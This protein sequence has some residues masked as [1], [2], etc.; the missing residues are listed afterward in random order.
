MKRFIFAILFALALPAQA[1]TTYFCNSTGVGADPVSISGS[2]TNTGASTLAGATGPKQ[3]LA[4]FV[5]AFAAA[6]AGDQLLMCNGGAWDNWKMGTTIPRGNAVGTYATNPIIIGNF[7]PTQFTSSALPILTAP[8]NVGTLAITGITKAFPAV[9][10]ANNA[11][12]NGDDVVIGV[13]AGMPEIEGTRGTVSAVTATSFSVNID[14]SLFTTAGT[15]GVGYLACPYNDFNSYCGAFSF[16]PTGGNGGGTTAYGGWTFQNLHIKGGPGYGSSGIGIQQNASFI[17]IKNM[18]IDHLDS[19]FGCNN[20]NQTVSSHDISLINNN[21]SYTWGHG[22]LSWGCNNVLIDG[23]TFDHTANGNR[24]NYHKLRDHAMYVSGNENLPAT[25]APDGFGII[26]RN[27]TITNTGLNQRAAQFPAY[28]GNAADINSCN[29]AVVVGH[30]RIA[31]WVFEN[32]LIM[33]AVGTA[34]QGCYGVG[35]GPANYD[36]PGYFEYQK[37]LVIRGNRII[38]VGNVAYET[39]P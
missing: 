12:L 13:I 22:L 3:T 27:N 20:S 26:I 35:F 5:A 6:V 8:G 2:D 32:N 38:N 39:G 31:N 4:A 10:T 28:G 9:V 34:G 30:A 18:T 19:A 23:N 37:N 29:A 15:T 25:N 33:Q 7:S 1:A 36:G 17:T 16:F 14:T 21:I 11:L 24:D